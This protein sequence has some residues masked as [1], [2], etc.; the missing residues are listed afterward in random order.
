MTDLSTTIEAKSSQLNAD[1]LMAGPRTVTITKVSANT[2][3]AEQPIAISYSGDNGKPFYP[4]KTVRRL[5]VTVWGPDGHEYVGRRMTLFR[6]PETTWGGLKVGGI[7][8][9]H[10]SHIDKPITLALTASRGN[11]KPF[12]VQPLAVDDPIAE[13]GRELAT[14]MKGETK[15]LLEWWSETAVRRDELNIPAERLAKMTDAVTKR[16]EEG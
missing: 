12:T 3:S 13:Y 6:D 10:V 16:A 11:K 2:S 5:L 7:R 8:V 1:D 4:C 14:Q 15:S 9:S